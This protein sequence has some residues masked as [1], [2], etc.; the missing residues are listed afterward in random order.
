MKTFLLKSHLKLFIAVALVAV[1]YVAAQ[2]SITTLPYTKADNF[3]AYNPTSATTATST[4]PTGWSF[5]GPANY[6]LR[7]AGT[8]SAGGFYGFGLNSDYSLGALRSG[9]TGDTY[10]YSVN[11][12]NNSGATITELTLSWDYEQ[13]RYAN[14]SGWNVTGTGQLSSNATLNSK[15][16][17][18]SNGGTNGTV[19]VTSVSSFTLTGLNI[20]PGQ[21]F[22]VTWVTTDEPGSDNGISIDN[23][24]MTAKNV[25]P[26]TWSGSAWSNGTGPN[27]AG[28]DDVFINGDYDGAGFK[29][30]NLTINSSLTVTGS[31]TVQ[32]AVINNGEIY[33][34]NDASFNQSPTGTY[35]GTPDFLLER[36]VSST[37]NK[38]AFWS[39]PVAAQS[40]YGIFSA[41]PAFV[42]TYNT[43][44]N[45]YDLVATPA[46]AIAGV[47][48]SIKTPAGTTKATFIGKPNNGVVTVPLLKTGDKYNLVGNP[49][50]SNLN[51]TTLLSVNSG[52]I[53]ST[54]WFWD[55]TSNSITT[56]NGSTTDNV[57]YATFNASGT[58]TWVNAPNKPITP[59]P[60]TT[61]AKVG[62]AFIV[63][64]LGT[65]ASDLTF[66]NSMRGEVAGINF[67]K[68]SSNASEGKYWLTLS[69]SY[70][71]NLTQAVTYQSGASNNF[72]D[73][74]SKAI[75][76]GSDAF[77]SLA[78]AEKVVIQG[79]SSFN[80]ND[81]V[82]LGDKHFQNGTFTIAVT[83]T[84]G[85]FANGQAIF[86]KD[87]LL[88]SI[89]NLQNGAYSFTSNAGE[90]INR[91]EIVY[92]QNVLGTQNT[93]VK[94]GIKVYRSGEDFIVESPAKIS[95]IE[96][97]EASGK[98]VK[99]IKS[100]GNKE[101]V[102]GLLK[103]V[104]I[105]KVVSATETISQKVIK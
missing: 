90:F 31:V 27:T 16:F 25:V 37:T 80:D 101:I 7:S 11:F 53:G 34:L 19:Y 97:Y 51:L 67:N 65:A 5:N 18:G 73:Y 93:I 10:S 78:N 43:G 76:L 45:F 58:G 88:G 36:N 98:L 66:N 12:T 55:N 95:S 94:D 22:G 62:Q 23:F 35:S 33:I 92:I 30:R 49:Y 56:Q 42:M 103:G 77:Y 40:M 48:Y 79:K 4:I 57:G 32:D 3:D 100:N 86:L 68:N 89:V 52:K 54:L 50:P 8:A 63:E 21:N 46:N 1:Q 87:K 84:E 74:D 47:G 41:A 24:N 105:I 9:S 70:N 72:D 39:S 69:T 91:F 99:S 17:I 44:S 15:D 13:W 96:V 82:L 61:F 104:Y 28:T 38:Y 71:S 59:I 102:S 64:A 6:K 60:T 85:I 75:D 2:L 81:V 26:V 83:N 20:A 14:A 29:A